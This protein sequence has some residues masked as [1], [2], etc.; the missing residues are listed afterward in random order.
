MLGQSEQPTVEQ[1]LHQEVICT[2]RGRA[3]A[4]TVCLVWV[5]AAFDLESVPL[6]AVQNISELGFALQGL[7]QVGLA[8]LLT[9]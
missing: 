5:P 1:Q 4:D 9:F 8:D 3:T 7:A 6:K 2:G